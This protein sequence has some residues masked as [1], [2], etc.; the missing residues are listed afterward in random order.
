MKTIKDKLIDA[1]LPILREEFVGRKCSDTNNLISLDRGTKTITDVSMVFEDYTI[2]GDYDR[3]YD[4]PSFQIY[5]HV[6]SKNGKSTRA[7]R[8]ELG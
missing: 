7:V 3:E 1:C 4:V 6:T 8:Y 5:L 2:Y